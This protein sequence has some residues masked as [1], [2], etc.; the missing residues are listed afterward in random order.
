MLFILAVLLVLGSFFA[1]SSNRDIFSPAKF[2]LLFFFLFHVG[3]FFDPP[4]TQVLSLVLIVLFVV[5]IMILVEGVQ[6]QYYPPPQAPI[7]NPE[8]ARTERRIIVPVI[9]AI[10]IPGILAQLFIIVQFGGI[11]GYVASINTRVQDWRGLGWAR[12]LIAMLPALNAVY[13]AFLLRGRAR[14]RTWG[15]FALHLSLVLFVGL[16]SGSRSGLLNIIAILCIVFHYQ[17]RPFSIP[18]AAGVMSSLVL[19]AS[20]LGVARNGLRY[21]DGEIQ[22]GLTNSTQAMSLNAFS[23]GI[24]PLELIVESPR[25][26]LAHGTTFLSLLTNAIPRAFYP[27]KPDTGGVFL[28]KEYAGN[29]WLGFSNLTPT[30]LGEWIIN[31]GWLLGIL[32]FFLTFG[33]AT[34]LIVNWYKRLVR[35][36]SRPRDALYVIDFV[37][38]IHVLWTIMA[39]MTGELT[40]VVLGHVLTQLIPLLSIRFYCKRKMAMKFAAPPAGAQALAK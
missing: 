34:L 31:F 10:T 35:D 1:I 19:L 39:V 25:L 28:T 17:K 18:L 6:T 38:Y 2:L 9:W 20:V 29:S 3:A 33:A 36:Q 37:I 14:A 27:G 40:S 22:T 13:F 8:V 12:T 15:I 26:V 32:G 4:D 30:F 7:V 21:V 16:L 23:Y 5:L 24:E 11:E